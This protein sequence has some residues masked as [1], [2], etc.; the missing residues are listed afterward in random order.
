[1]TTQNSTTETPLALNRVV[2]G[3]SFNDTVF[4][5]SFYEIV[6]EFDKYATKELVDGSWG[7]HQNG[8]TVM[9]WCDENK[10]EAL[11]SLY[12]YGSCPNLIA[13]TPDEL[14]ECLKCWLRNR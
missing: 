7:V 10:R 5:N 6:Q 13:K 3:S 9:V 8:H 4:A 11:V 14:R 1:M 12:G 2:G